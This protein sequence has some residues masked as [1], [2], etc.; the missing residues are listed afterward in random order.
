MMVG[1]AESQFAAAVSFFSDKVAYAF[2]HAR[3]KRIDM[4]MHYKVNT[5]DTITRTRARTHTDMTVDDLYVHI[6]TC[7][8]IYTLI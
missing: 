3:E 4:L 7:I 2:Q 5:T 1:R 6:F 8:Y